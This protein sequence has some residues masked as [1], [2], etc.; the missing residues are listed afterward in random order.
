MIV[1][2]IR[3]SAF[4]A[5]DTTMRSILAGIVLLS[6]STIAIDVAKAEQYAKVQP[7]P[8]T[9]RAPVGHRQPTPADVAG[10]GH[11]QSDKKIVDK[12]NEL[13][14]LPPSQDAVTG[15]DQLQSEENALAKKIEQENTRLDRL[16]RGICRGC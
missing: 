9:T 8:A 12:D 11:V 2:A 15:A 4:N 3:L 13:L 1:A 5:E 10:P 6:V 7:G 16:L 14:E